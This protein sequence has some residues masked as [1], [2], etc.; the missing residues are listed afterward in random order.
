MRLIGLTGG[1]ATGKTTVSNYLA[2]T[3]Q[4]PIW[5]A[6]LYA[7]E[8]VQIGS[9]VLTAIEQHYGSGILNADRSLNRTKLGQ[10]IF[11]NADERQWLE[12]QIHPFVRCRFQENIVSFKTVNS[13]TVNSKI[14]N[15]KTTNPKTVRFR[16]EKSAVTQTPTAVLAIPLLF[17]VEMTDLVTEIWAVY[18]SQDQ[19]LQRLLQREGNR[20]S[21]E[22]AQARIQSQMSLAE[23]CQRADVVLGNT[24]TLDALYHQI[25]Q[26]L[27]H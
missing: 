13:K 24:S 1:I 4:L 11:S 23:K 12:Q 6:D 25:D 26:A 8:A 9:P 19:Q 10:I 20:L 27:L 5:D 21:I 15:L 14:A 2:E 17:E 3:Y 16:A 7:R 18:C 22:E